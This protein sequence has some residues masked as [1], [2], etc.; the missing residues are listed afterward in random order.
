MK[1]TALEEYGFRCMLLL[2]K[3]GQGTSLT[4]TEFAD[5]ERLSIPYAAKLLT[6]LKKAGL[7]KSVRGRNGGY[8]LARSAQSILLKEIFDSLGDPVFSPEHCDRYTGNEEF[9][10][11][12][13]D[14]SVR[15]IWMSFD[16]FI[17]SMLSRITLAEV[18]SGEVDLFHTVGEMVGRI[19][20]GR[21]TKRENNG[22]NSTN[23]R[24]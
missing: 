14:C 11:H 1:I 12:T 6:L 17:S 24:Q 16:G 21:E 13:D 9:C 5:H 19:D 23:E 20:S 22:F 15:H 7:V 8:A 2:A 4:L 18:A 3:S 10:V